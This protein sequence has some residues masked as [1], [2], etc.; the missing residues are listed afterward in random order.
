MI[1]KLSA[2][3]SLKSK[4]MCLR[5]KTKELNKTTKYKQNKKGKLIKR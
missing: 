5:T 4:G 1:N 2:K 3:I